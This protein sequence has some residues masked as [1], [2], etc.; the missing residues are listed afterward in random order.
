MIDKNEIMEVSQ[1]V[2]LRA[3]VVEKDYILSWLLAGINWHKDLKTKWIFKG[4]TCL[5]KC[6]FETYRF[7][8]DLDFTVTDITHL[9][10]EYLKEKFIEIAEM[11]YEESGIKC[12]EELITFKLKKNKKGNPTIEGKVGYIGPMLRTV[13][14]IAKIKLDLTNDEIVVLEPAHQKLYHPYTDDPING[15]SVR[16]YG[17]EEVFAEKTRAL[18]ER[19]RPRDLYDVIHLFRNNSHAVNKSLLLSTL[20]KKCDFKQI[21]VPTYESIQ[22]HKK[23]GELESEWENMLSH[24]LPLLPS[25][26]HFMGELPD[27]F[28]WLHSTK[29]PV[30]LP[31]TGLK[32]GEEK[33][34]PGRIRTYGDLDQSVQKIK[35]AA[36]NRVC[37]RLT[38]SRK[39]R[40]IEPYSF[41]RS[42]DGARLFYGWH[43]EAGQI[44]CFRIDRFEALEV[45][46][47]SYTP[48]FHVEISSN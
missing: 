6:Y 2:N 16:C 22:K 46:N 20:K 1:A 5:K 27:F 39:V 14:S 28:E 38:Y 32:S 33:W 36:A 30:I 12:P 45:T 13:R 35:F 11:L 47:I 8:E 21:A 25:L 40:T 17:Y 7:S 48:R 44:K 24:Q 9:N 41:R 15:I 19:A 29:E 43:Q 34:Q 18:A 31:E 3:D 37:I 23:Y 10:P 26:E 4:G 42:R